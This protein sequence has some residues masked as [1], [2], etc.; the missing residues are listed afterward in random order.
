[1]KIQGHI[2]GVTGKTEHS[3][4][5]KQK[6]T[7]KVPFT[8]ILDQATAK[9]LD[10]KGGIGPT[11][12]S[13]PDQVPRLLPAQESALDAGEHALE[14]LGHLSGMLGA[15][16]LTRGEA[17]TLSRTINEQVEQLGIIRNELDKSDPLRDTID[18]IRVLGL[19]ESIK[20]DRG[21]YSN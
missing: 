13:P 17:G 2:P 3:A 8:S 11:P 7:S 15:R 14:V 4:R 10:T 19:V 1:M 6:G 18:Q 16:G 20:L 9:G 21:D 5:G 12:P